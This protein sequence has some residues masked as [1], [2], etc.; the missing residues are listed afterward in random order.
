VRTAK[1]STR[2]HREGTISYFGKEDPRLEDIRRRGQDAFT[3][4]DWAGFRAME[5]E[6]RSDTAF[7]TDIWAPITAYAAWKCGEDDSRA[8]LE[9]AIEGGFSGSGD[10]NPLL[11]ETF[12]ADADWGEVVEAMR[13]NVPAP[14]IEILDWPTSRPSRPIRLFR[15]SEEREALLRELIPSPD[16][17]AWAS[18]TQLLGWVAGRWNHS[19]A[20]VDEQDA[21]EILKLVD[22]GMRFTCVEYATVLSQALNASRIPA[23]VVRVYAED[24]HVGMGKGHAVAEAW[25]DGL[26]DWVLLDGQNGIYWADEDGAPLGVPALQERF[27]SG[28]PRGAPVGPG[29]SP[30]SDDDAEHWWQ[31]FAYAL[32]TGAAWSDAGFVPIFQSEAVIGEEILLRDRSEAYPDLAEIAIGVTSV[33]G[34]AAIRAQTEH[35]YAVGFEI[36]MSG[37]EPETIALDGGWALPREPAGE[38][39]ATIATTTPYAALAPSTLTFRIT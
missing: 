33:D 35:P 32:P 37:A 28:E 5:S 10:L 27:Q 31:Y 22:E 11:T 23:R 29:S 1:I 16:D 6:L 38:H 2:S 3:G 20:H 25:I 19:N 12:G 30:M 36:R 15:L 14:P 21:V 24:Y 13:A 17:T 34:R 18:A 8:F 7:W 39:E 9:E 26:D 4:E